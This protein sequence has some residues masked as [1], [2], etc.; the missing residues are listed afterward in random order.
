MGSVKDLEIHSVPMDDHNGFGTFVFSDRYS[1]FDWGTMPDRIPN[2][3]AAI[4]MMAAWNF[5][6]FEELK[7]PSHYKRV[8]NSNNDIVPL[9]KLTEPSTEMAV[10]LSEVIEPEFKNGKYDY[11]N[12]ENR[13]FNNF[14]IP[15]EVIYRNGAPKGSSLFKTLDKLENSGDY[16]GVSKLLGK[17]DLTF[18]PEPGDLF[19]ITGFDFTTKFESK[20]RPISD[21]EAFRISGLSD[22]QFKQLI[23]LRQYAVDVVR[24]RTEEVGLIDFDGKHEYR[25]WNNIIEIADVFGTPDENRF[26]FNGRQVSKEFL[27]QVYKA[28]QPEWVNDVELAKTSADKQG[29]SNWKSLTTIKPKPLDPK[30][31][32]LVG[33]MY[34]SVSD[35]YTGMNLFGARDLEAVMD[36]LE[37]YYPN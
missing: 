1:V 15:L 32:E 18:R 5:E 17:Y 14:V 33:E 16:V 37:P 28:E 35:R 6:R 12:F 4:C 13:K 26:M 24:S 20:D 30:L 8:V 9:S 27:R 11:S 23:N 22:N 2:K 25:L 36:D 10:S 3:G 31:I 21:E 34:A 7:L 19:P 29:I